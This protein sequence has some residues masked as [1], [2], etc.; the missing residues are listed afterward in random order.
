MIT[1]QKKKRK[2]EDVK[3][4]PGSYGQLVNVFINTEGNLKK[5]KKKLSS[6]YNSKATIMRLFRT[7]KT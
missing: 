5:K 2:N 6:R 1:A 3:I 4:F 7:Q